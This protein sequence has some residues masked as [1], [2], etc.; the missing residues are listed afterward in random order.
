MCTERRLLVAQARATGMHQHHYTVEALVL[1]QT[2]PL[3]ANAALWACCSLLWP[4]RLAVGSAHVN[5]QSTEC[6]GLLQ[7]CALRT[8]Q[9]TS[10]VLYDASL[11]AAMLYSRGNAR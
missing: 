10:D 5:V 1:A 4:Y 8:F 7:Q 9:S 6:I 11:S 3:V 2:E